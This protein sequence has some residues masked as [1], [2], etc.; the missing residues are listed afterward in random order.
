MSFVATAIVVSTAV[1]AY[2]SYKSG[3]AAKK[4]GKKQSAAAQLQSWADSMESLRQYQ[5][6]QA[7][8]STA[9]QG[10]GAS[11]ESSGAQGVRS[12]LGASEANNQELLGMSVG[13]SND[14]YKAMGDANRWQTVSSIAGSIS[15]IAGSIGSIM[16]QDPG[17]SVSSGPPRRYSA[18]GRGRT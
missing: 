5:Q 16:P 6:A 14:Y 12:S 8:S 7:V 2:G 10:S 18:K 4:A 15:S 1:S 9:F 17:T 11:L 13:L 3:Q